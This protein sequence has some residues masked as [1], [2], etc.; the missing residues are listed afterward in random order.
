M[1]VHRGV[2]GLANLWYRGYEWVW[3]EFVGISSDFD[4]FP[5]PEEEERWHPSAREK[6]RAEW[7]ER[8]QQLAEQA[9]DVARRFLASDFQSWPAAGPGVAA[10]AGPE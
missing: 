3:A 5:S 7:D 10:D 9:R 6:Y 8:R 1:P 4:D 2:H